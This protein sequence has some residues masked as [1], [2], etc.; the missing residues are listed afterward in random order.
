[1]VATVKECAAMLAQSESITKAEAERRIKSVVEVIA[2]QCIENGGV[3]FKG[4][5]TIETKT[6]P[7]RHGKCAGREYDSPA[8]KY[9][10]IRTGSG[11]SAE[12]NPDQSM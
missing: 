2:S 9:L 4:V 1:M 10:T 5:F 7:A 8:K 3:S 11:L 6:R 12:L